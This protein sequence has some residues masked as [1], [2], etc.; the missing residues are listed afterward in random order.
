MIGVFPFLEIRRV[1]L[2]IDTNGDNKLSAGEILRG[3]QLLGINPTREE[4]T[5]W[6]SQ[7][8]KDGKHRTKYS[9][10]EKVHTCMCFYIRVSI[11]YL[12]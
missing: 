10:L 7:T 5:S 12:C 6:M 2:S 3:A 1:Y 4:V 9:M 11:Q 8:D